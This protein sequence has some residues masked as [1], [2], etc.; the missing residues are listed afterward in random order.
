MREEYR[1]S[2][3]WTKGPTLQGFEP[4]GILSGSSGRIT[5]TSGPVA[6]ASDVVK[7]F[8]EMAVLE[9]LLR[10]DCPAARSVDEVVEV[11]RARLSL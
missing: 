4:H 8:I 6:P 2:I 11:D 10:H 9:V 7:V 1:F 3:E 5:L